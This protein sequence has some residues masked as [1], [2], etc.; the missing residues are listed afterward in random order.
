MKHSER[1]SGHSCRECPVL[2]L[3]HSL[4]RTRAAWGIT[5]RPG[6]ILPRCMGVRGIAHLR[7]F[8][9]LRICRSAP[10]LRIAASKCSSRTIEA[11]ADREVAAGSVSTG[12]PDLTS[13]ARS[14][15]P[16]PTH[17]TR[18]GTAKTLALDHNNTSTVGTPFQ[19]RMQQVLSSD[20]LVSRLGESRFF[21]F[22]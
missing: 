16:C 9:M 17:A 3:T 7:A 19:P 12:D 18:P 1:E 22:E 10:N 20:W 13:A 15:Q 4:A 11:V 2:T 14:G 6:A 21:T 8:R 5:N